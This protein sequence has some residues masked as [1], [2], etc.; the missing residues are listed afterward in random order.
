MAPATAWVRAR[1]G[2]FIRMTSTAS[3][4]PVRLRPATSSLPWGRE[5]TRDAFIWLCFN[6]QSIGCERDTFCLVRLK[7]PV[8]FYELTAR[9]YGFYSLRAAWAGELNPPPSFTLRGRNA[10]GTAGGTPALRIQE[11]RGR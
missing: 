9:K 6:T 3:R 11:V 4:M 1:W 2:S 5:R 7:V 8:S 10:L